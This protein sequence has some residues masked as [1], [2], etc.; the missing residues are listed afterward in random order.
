MKKRILIVE[1]EKLQIKALTQFLKAEGYKVETAEN[2]VA[3]INLMILHDFDLVICDIVMSI[4]SGIDFLVAIREAFEHSVPVI[5]VSSNGSQKQITRLKEFEAVKFLPKPLSL[6]EL[7]RT[8]ESY[9][10]KSA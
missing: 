1:D 10:K 2:G 5:M 4:L 9:L 6:P 8:V 3:A 7:N